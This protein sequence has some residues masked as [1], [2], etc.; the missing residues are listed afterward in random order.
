MARPSP[1][2]RRAGRPLPSSRGIP[3]APSLS[4]SATGHLHLDSGALAGLRLHGELS[5]DA[6][7]RGRASRPGRDDGRTRR[8][9]RGSKPQPSSAIRSSA[10]WPLRVRVTSTV[11][12][13]ECRRALCSASWAT[14]STASSWAAGSARTLWAAKVTRAEWARSRTWAC[15]RRVATR[16]SSSRAAGR[17]SMTAAR[18]SSAASAASAATW[19]SSSLARAG[20]RSTR[21]VAAWAVRRSEKSFWA[22]ASCSSWASRAR[23]PAM[24]SS[25]LRS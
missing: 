5:A 14:R 10:P 11:L 20:S 22:T 13:P 16:P 1:V 8:T 23:S 25:R 3:V 24:V 18:S 15:E 7:R 12:A 6:M 19:C 4:L 9:A 2:G 17:S 21:A